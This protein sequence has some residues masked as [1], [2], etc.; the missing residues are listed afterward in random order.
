VVLDGHEGLDADVLGQVEGLVRRGGHLV[1]RAAPEGTETGLFER[2][3]LGMAMEARGAEPAVLEAAVGETRGTAEQA[4]VVAE[5]TER[6]LAGTPSLIALVADRGR[7]KS[8]A[9]G[10]A[11]AA[12][13]EQTT[14]LR[15]V[16][17]G[18]GEGGLQEVLRFAGEV[19]VREPAE[20]AGWLDGLDEREAPQVIVIDEAAQLPVPLLQRITRLAPRATL[21]FATT[22]RGYEGTGRGFVLRFLAWARS[23]GR[24]FRELTLR[25]PIRFD[26]GDPLEAWITRVLALDAEPAAAPHQAPEERVFLGPRQAPEER[27]F[28]RPRRAPEERVFLRLE[29]ARLAAD[30][31]LLRQVFGLLVHAHYRTRPA[32]LARLL[33]APELSV[34][35]CMEGA[36]VL[37]V[38]LVS[39]EGGLS[40]ELCERLARGEGRIQGHA[41]PDTLLSHG[42]ATEAGELTFA[43]SVRI[44]VHPASRREGLASA[45][46][47]HVH[48]AH[49]VDA[50]G[51][52]FGA[53]TEVVR[54]RQ[55][56]GYELVRVGASRG[57]RT[58]E[59]AAVMV[60]PVSRRAAALVAALRVELAR[61]LPWQLRAFAAE[62]L[63]LDAALETALRDG[64]PAPPPLSPADRD[65]L[66]E[67]YTTSARPA[68]TLAH[69]LCS[70]VAE[71]EGS[72]VTLDRRSAALLRARWVEELPWREAA[73]CAGYRHAGDAMRAM[74]SAV[75]ALW[76]ATR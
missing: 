4:A 26:P 48:G 38:S 5:L 2:R 46:V 7:G 70:F 43:R 17:G 49:E 40:Q 59:P 74:R 34:H 33:E 42:G 32:D 64:L 56:L 50:F 65:A 75:A 35:A 22:C 18:A 55:K 54:F 73:A 29:P 61:N 10:L 19:P 16:V 62:G 58:G 15:V 44:A 45:L 14:G 23:E 21:A 36:Q 9:L 72:L 28:L 53:T 25:E 12:A 60:R 30:E 47:E 67:T 39:R 37:A 41:L 68:D 11:L 20:L 1:L 3:V 6:F 13:R 8:S 71:H 57:A 63:P 76:R 52:L 51:T 69:A 27:V 31:G 66:V 24:A